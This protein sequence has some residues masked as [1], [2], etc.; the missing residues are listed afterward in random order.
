MLAQYA[1]YIAGALIVLGLAGIIIPVIPGTLLIGLAMVGW[2]A[3]TGGSTAWT[4]A[5]IVVILLGLGFVVK[6]AV[7]HRRLRDAGVPPS[8]I[9]VG[10]IL[11]VIGFFA[12]PVVGLFIGFIGG[13]WLAEARRLG[14]PRAWPSTKAALMATGL[15]LLIELTSGLLA[16]AVFIGAA[17]MT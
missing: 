13:V 14:A 7:P 11:G 4:A 3:I 9:I 12:I 5:A 6:F 16:T 15:S 2:A 8:T 10:A 1:D 17:V